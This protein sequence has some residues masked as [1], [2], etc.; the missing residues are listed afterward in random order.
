MVTAAARWAGI[1]CGTSAAAATARHPT[2]RHLLYYTQFPINPDAIALASK[3]ASCAAMVE[4]EKWTIQD[5][6]AWLESLGLGTLK[7]S[8]TT[9]AV[10][11][12]E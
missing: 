12:G 10:D 9:N 2:P 8:F 4:L 1:C 5:C 11:G 6:L 3:L 7:D